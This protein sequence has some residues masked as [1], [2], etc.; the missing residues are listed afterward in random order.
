MWEWSCKVG[1]LTPVLELKIKRCAEYHGDWADQMI[2]SRA[3]VGHSDLVT[4]HGQVH[5]AEPK[6]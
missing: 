4:S 2:V 6:L 3:L 1:Y 5:K